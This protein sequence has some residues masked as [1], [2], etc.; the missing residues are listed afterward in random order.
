MILSVERKYPKGN[1][2]LIFSVTLMAI[3]SPTFFVCLRK[4]AEQGSQPIYITSVK[5]RNCIF[6]LFLPISAFPRRRWIHG[7]EIIRPGCPHPSTV[8][9]SRIVSSHRASS[10]GL[11]GIEL[12]GEGCEVKSKVLWDARWGAVNPAAVEVQPGSNSWSRGP[13]EQTTTLSNV[14]IPLRSSNVTQPVTDSSYGSC[15]C[16]G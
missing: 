14:P 8:S 16:H 7:P 15:P 3:S 9:I 2:L 5:I 4:S 1:Y 10:P 6:S 12:G 13:N 11:D